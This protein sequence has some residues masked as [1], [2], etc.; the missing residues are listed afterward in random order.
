M[1]STRSWAAFFPEGSAMIA[2]IL[3][4]QSLKLNEETSAEYQVLGAEF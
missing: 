2:A 1:R 4:D 3:R